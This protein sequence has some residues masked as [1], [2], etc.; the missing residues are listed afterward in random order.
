MVVWVAIRIQ[1][2][3]RAMRAMRI[4]ER[5]RRDV[6]RDVQGIHSEF[7]KKEHLHR[8]RQEEQYGRHIF[9]VQSIFRVGL[10]RARVRAIVRHRRETRRNDSA[11]MIQRCWRNGKAQQAALQ[12][13]S[14]LIEERLRLKRERERQDGATRIQLIRRQCLA[15]REL[16]RRKAAAEEAKSEKELRLREDAATSIQRIWRGLRGRA[17]WASL[18]VVRQR[19]RNRNLAATL[20]QARQ[21][22]IVSR[23]HMRRRLVAEAKAR[24]KRRLE[25][26]YNAVV[27]IQCA[28]RQKLARK[29]QRSRRQERRAEDVERQKN[30]ELERRLEEL[31]RQQEQHLLVMRIQC[32]AR[33]R[34]ARKRVIEVKELRAQQEIERGQRVRVLAATHI[35]AFVRGSLARAWLSRHRTRLQKK[36]EAMK[37]LKYLKMKAEK[38]V[39]SINMR[40]MYLEQYGAPD[41]SIVDG[42]VGSEEA[43]AHAA[44][45]YAYHTTALLQQQQQQQQQHTGGVSWEKYYDESA[46]AYYWYNQETGEASWT[47]P[48]GGDMEEA[49]Y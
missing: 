33:K 13:I 20:I 41:A 28:I 37:R 21:R 40:F 32:C 18:N 26:E 6:Q 29:Q 47:N 31:H 48:T 3:F 12:E 46:Q 8:L 39:E 27:T 1:A 24:E 5:R 22:G 2:R 23:A 49:A 16:A 9:R 30:E 25:R 42:L 36:H 15:R 19:E 38:E 35:Q 11:R 7:W 4:A 44:A 45:S 43:E 10:A 14:R 34:L 17:K